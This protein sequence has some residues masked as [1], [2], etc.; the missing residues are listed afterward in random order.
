MIKLFFFY[1]LLQQIKLKKKTGK[2]YES[3]CERIHDPTKPEDCYGK[4]C[5]FI[6][7]TCCYMES[8]VSN[9]SDLNNIFNETWYECVDFAISDYEGENQKQIAIEQIKNGTY[10][11]VYNDTY[12]DIILLKCKCNFLFSYGILLLFLFLFLF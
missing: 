11:E 9:N 3:P 12:L 5:E 7:E 4:S 1:L 6:E 8:I 10:W 2:V